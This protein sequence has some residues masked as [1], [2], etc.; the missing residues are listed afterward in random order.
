MYNDLTD[1][2]GVRVYGAELMAP[3]TEGYTRNNSRGWS[4]WRQLSGGG[5]G[6]A[7]N[8]YGGPLHVQIQRND[9]LILDVG[10]AN[11]QAHF[12]QATSTLLG[13]DEREFVAWALATRVPSDVAAGWVAELR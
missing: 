9:T 12:W 5:L 13:S 1:L 6:V 8:E 10:M 3:A 4:Y 7:S 2:S 11:V